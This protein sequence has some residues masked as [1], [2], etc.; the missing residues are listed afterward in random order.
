MARRLTNSA[1]DYINLGLWDPPANTSAITMLMWMAPQSTPALDYRYFDKSKNTAESQI[2]IMLS[3]YAAGAF[4]QQRVRL[5]VDSITVTGIH[6]AHGITFGDWH[7]VGFKWSSTLGYMYTYYD[8]AEDSSNTANAGSYITTQTYDAHIGA[9][10]A[11]GNTADAEFAD[12]CI[13]DVA[14]NN[15]EIAAIAN[16]VPAFL[17]RPQNIIGYWPCYGRQSPEP[18][19]S[20]RGFNGTLVG[21]SYATHAPIVVKPSFFWTPTIFDLG[22]TGQTVTPGVATATATAHSPTS[23]GTGTA[24]VTPSIASVAAAANEPGGSGS[25]TAT[26]TPGEA[27]A[28]G[29]AH[30]PT[31]SLGTATVTPD[32]ASV[33]AAAHSPAAAGAGTAPVTPDEASATATAHSPTTAGTGTATVT[34]GEA[35]AVAAAHSPTA[36][37]GGQVVQADIASAT[38]AA[39]SPATGGTGT[40]TVT[41]DTASTVAAAHSPVTIGTGNV[42]V[43]PGVA[44]ATAVAH[45]AVAIS[46]EFHEGLIEGWDIPDTG[47]KWDVPDTGKNWDIPDTGKGWTV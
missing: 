44:T 42:S 6:G 32:T 43:S 40:A 36:V 5:Q 13:W 4:I 45:S 2:Y 24:T 26:V 15:A 23:A 8:G 28:T 46:G 33:A 41:P 17:I 47:K 10:Q 31:L 38:A 30:D 3:N 35:S 20:G 34:P 29:T 16:G 18:D 9:T 1:S 37:Q 39:Y 14:L 22:V 7:H 19:L 25:G 21:T 11:G 27:S 12:V